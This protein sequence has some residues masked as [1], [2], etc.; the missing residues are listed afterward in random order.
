MFIAWIAFSISSTFFLF[1]FVTRVEPGLATGAIAQFYGLTDADFGTLASL[2]FWVY[3][4]MQIVVGLLLDRYGAR[5][6]ILLGSFTC[7]A[8]M[9]IFAAT[10]SVVIGG[11]GRALTGFGG[12]FA[13][14]AALWL[15]NHWF[16]PERFAVLSGGVNAVGMLGTAIGAVALTDIIGQAGWRT[17]FVAT[18]V[19]G[20]VIFLIALLFLR[21]PPSPAA[22]A[23][24]GPGEHIRQSLADVLGHPRSWALGIVGLLYYMPV[25]VYAG[26]W[27][28]TELM[29]D[30]QLARVAAETAVSM[31]FWGTAAG[32]VAGGWLSDSLGHRKYL[33]FF[34]AVL[35][36]LAYAGV[37]YLPGSELTVGAL[38]FAAGFFGGFEMLVFAMAKEGQPNRLAGTVVAFVNMVGIAG[39]L[40]FQPLVGYL[41]DITGGDFHAALI[42]VPICAGL[43]ALLVLTLPE[44]RHP[45]HRPG[46]RNPQDSAQAAMA[47]AG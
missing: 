41:A 36:G 42:S 30:H 10:S 11:F 47:A 17:V 28:T 23:T 37:L 8:G 25:N 45:E 20:L 22:T 21:E 5:R 35:T 44:Y 15:T 34:G 14:V 18:G 24:T 9:L 33:V 12:A 27:G 26:L 3:A 1:E 6:F 7:A 46:A 16:A 19:A 13:F 2:F 39:A 31:I 43:A 38:L 4:P 40:V 29:K 32:S